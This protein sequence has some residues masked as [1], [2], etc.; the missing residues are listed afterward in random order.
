MNECSYRFIK[1]VTLFTKSQA[2]QNL[3]YGG[4]EALISGRPRDTKTVRD[5]SWPLTRMAL[6]S[7]H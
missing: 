3:K 1:H 2:S 5:W 6:V 7:G 4:S